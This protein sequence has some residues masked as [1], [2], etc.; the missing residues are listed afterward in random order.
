MRGVRDTKSSTITAQY[1]GTFNKQEV[2][3]EF[4]NH[5]NLESNFDF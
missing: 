2:K 4:L 3:E 5:V 1:S